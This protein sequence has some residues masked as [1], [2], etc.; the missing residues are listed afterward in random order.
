MQQACIENA[1][2]LQACRIEDIIQSWR[3][4]RG[5][6]AVPCVRDDA[7]SATMMLA[8]DR[9]NVFRVMVAGALAQ[10]WSG[11]AFGAAF[12][13]ILAQEHRRQMTRRLADA[14]RRQTPS[15]TRARKSLTRARKCAG[16]DV[17]ID[18]LLLPLRSGSTGRAGSAGDAMVLVGLSP[19][20]MQPL[21]QNLTDC[22]D[23][24]LDCSGPLPGFAAPVIQP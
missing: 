9:D 7:L 22:R 3:R 21:C 1:C 6:R 24:V 20:A 15:L 23:M 17:E 2:M 5:E 11:L 12:V 4:L 13:S 19:V 8:P 16:S 14:A 18:I 10:R